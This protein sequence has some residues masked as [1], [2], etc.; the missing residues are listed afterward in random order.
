MSQRPGRIVE[1][2]A[3]PFA[4]RDERDSRAIKS[5]PEFVAMREHV[6]SRI[7]NSARR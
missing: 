7:W 6:L 3:A 2:I 1:R 4:R 5:L